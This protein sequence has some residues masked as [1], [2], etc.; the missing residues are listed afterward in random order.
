MR[1]IGGDQQDAFPVLCQLDCQRARRCGL[2]YPSLAADEDPAKRLLL[3]DGLERWVH[4][5]EFE[6]VSRHAS[7]WT[8]DV[9]NARLGLGYD[10]Y[11]LL[12]KSKVRV[13]K[14][15]RKRL[16]KH[17]VTRYIQRS[18][19]MTNAWFLLSKSIYRRSIP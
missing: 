13:L 11:T 10:M 15:F 5:F 8:C 9:A 3:D 16:N 14:R 18:L 12:V 4:G 2:A 6:V 19:V 17:M 7:F 1:W